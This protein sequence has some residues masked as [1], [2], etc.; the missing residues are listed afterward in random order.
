MAVRTR[1]TRVRFSKSRY[2]D[3]GP[4]GQ[5]GCGRGSI[6]PKLGT[7]LLEM[8]MPKP[9]PRSRPAAGR[10]LQLRTHPPALPMRCSPRPLKSPRN[11]AILHRPA[12][13]VR[14]PSVRRSE[15]RRIADAAIEAVNSRPGGYVRRLPFCCQAKRGRGCGLD[16]VAFDVESRC[17]LRSVTPLA[18]SPVRDCHAGSGAR[19]QPDSGAR[20]AQRRRRRIAHP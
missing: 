20:C 9:T 12:D 8:G 3:S 1:S 16:V 4:I 19:P 15:W 14:H 2:R 7:I 13:P 18:H 17:A 6:P 10:R 5:S 11:V